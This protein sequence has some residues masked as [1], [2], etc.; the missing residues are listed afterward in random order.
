MSTDL[1][2]S[3]PRGRRRLPG[4]LSR[5]SWLSALLV[6]RESCT[7]EHIAPCV[8]SS[9]HL[10]EAVMV[11]KGA[12]IHDRIRGWTN[13]HVCALLD[14]RKLAV[15]LL[16]R[17]MDVDPLIKEPA[18][19]RVRLFVHLHDILSASELYTSGST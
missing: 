15:D 2:R 14:W 3:L 6:D 16:R 5:W 18:N 13:L 7:T 1:I 12:S 17:G 9:L 8:R 4:V 11:D 10:L 19:E